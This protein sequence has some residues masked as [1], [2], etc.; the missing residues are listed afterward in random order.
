MAVTPVELPDRVLEVLGHAR[1]RPEGQI[2]AAIGTDEA[3]PAMSL[4]DLLDEESR[5]LDG[6]QGCRGGLLR[7]PTRADRVGTLQHCWQVPTRMAQNRVIP[8]SRA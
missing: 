1:R 8:G 4:V 5:T 6:L 7:V 2:V 3:P